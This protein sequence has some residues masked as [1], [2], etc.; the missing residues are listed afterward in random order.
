[1]KQAVVQVFDDHLAD[2]APRGGKYR[3]TK[4]TSL[5]HTELLSSADQIG[6]QAV[7]GLV[8]GKAEVP[9]SITVEHSGNGYDWKPKNAAPEISGA[10]PS[11][12]TTSTLVGGERWPV[13]PSLRF[14]RL[15]IDAG[16]SANPFALA[17]KVY[18][19]ARSR[20]IR[21]PRHEP[22][23]P[24]LPRRFPRAALLFGVRDETLRELHELVQASQH[25]EGAARYDQVMSGMS[26]RAR[27]EIA[28]LVVRLRGLDPNS[29]RLIVSIARGVIRLLSEDPAEGTSRQEPLARPTASAGVAGPEGA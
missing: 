17:L 1:V 8:S 6:L 23:P 18:V 2:M 22:E 19:S 28:R 13:R 27:H 26:A 20:M 9:L 25:I 10:I 11:T 15:R 24:P 3:V 21:L 7:V 29:K 16:D 4:Y 12:A 14:V 5:E